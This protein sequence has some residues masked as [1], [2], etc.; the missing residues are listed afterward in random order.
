[1]SFRKLFTRHAQGQIP[2]S[3]VESTAASAV[4]STIS[5]VTVEN[6]NPSAEILSGFLFQ[7]VQARLFMV[8][9]AQ[10]P[11]GQEVGDI[12]RIAYSDNLTPTILIRPNDTSHQGSHMHPA[13]KKAF[14]PEEHSSKTVQIR[15][16]LWPQVSLELV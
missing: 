16:F 3:F 4:I 10:W 12:G 7:G 8:T 9:K 14:L 2:A 15:S 5:Y 1:V 6:P 13:E 11:L